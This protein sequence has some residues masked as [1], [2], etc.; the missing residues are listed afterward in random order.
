MSI[1]K[2]VSFISAQVISQF[3]NVA[4]VVLLSSGFYFCKQFSPLF[5]FLV[6]GKYGG[7]L[8]SVAVFSHVE[9][10]ISLGFE[11]RKQ[12]NACIFRQ[13]R[14]QSV[15]LLLFCS[16]SSLVI[17]TAIVAISLFACNDLFSFKGITEICP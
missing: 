15:L 13:Q 1:E 16:K 14:K 4:L 2:E 9:G 12:K 10:S 8:R 11:L 5:F 7:E 6:C 3:S 17:S